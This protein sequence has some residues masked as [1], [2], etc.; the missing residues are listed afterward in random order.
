MLMEVKKQLRYLYMG[1]KCNIKS[2]SEYKSNFIIQTIFMFINNG[3]F[4][5]F[6]SIIFSQNGGNIKG[7]GMEQIMYLWGFSTISFGVAYFF[8]GGTVKISRS[9]I[10]GELDSYLLQPKHPLIGIITS[11]CDFSACGDMI[12]GLTMLIFATGGDVIKIVFGIL[13]GIL[14]SVFYISTEVIFRSLAVW[15]G[16][17][18]AVADKYSNTLLTTF[19]IYPEQIFGTVLKIILY[20]VI[21]AAYLS[22]LPIKIINEFNFVTL[23][24]LIVIEVIYMFIAI[25]VFNSAIKKY[26]SGNNIAMKE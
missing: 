20:T 19:S 18:D 12:Y 3:Y 10:S 1:L 4:I 16:D 9:I 6:W 22:Y 17:M 25:L 26:E 11:K 21:P 13:L 14:G 24:I 23:L 7:I 5:I 15:L 2:A 8:F